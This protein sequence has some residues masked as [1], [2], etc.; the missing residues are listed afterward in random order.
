MIARVASGYSATAGDQDDLVQEILFAVWRALPS[1]RGES[2]ERTFVLR[3]AHNRGLSF[4]VRRRSFEPLDAETLVDPAPQPDAA[5][6]TLQASER[7]RMAIRHLPAAQ[8]E[9]VMLFLEGLSRREIALIQGTT[10]NNV[11]VRLTRAQ[12]ALRALLGDT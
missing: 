2:S 11:G 6:L 10:E 7:L 8:R 4:S 12:H 9:A 5:L 1:F 3:I